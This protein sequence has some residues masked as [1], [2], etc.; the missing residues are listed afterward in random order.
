VKGLVRIFV[1]A[2]LLVHSLAPAD[3]STVNGRALM[4]CPSVDEEI[5]DLQILADGLKQSD[6]VGLFEKIR[7]KSAIDDLLKRMQ[8]FHSGDG[9]FSAAELQ[10]QYD[11][12][13]MRIASH[14][15]DKDVILHSQLCNAWE[16]IW[17]DLED[18]DRFAEKFS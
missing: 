13:L 7:L 15:Q 12:L 2:F 8:K 9:K 10:E 17:Q 6:A 11:V 18:P 1:P 3:P 14:L 4:A 5:V 16:M